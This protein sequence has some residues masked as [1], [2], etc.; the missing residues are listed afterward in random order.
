MREPSLMRVEAGL[1]LERMRAPSRP[2]FVRNTMHGLILV[3]SG[4]KRVRE[5]GEEWRLCAGEGL[6]FAQGNHFVSHNS[7]D[8]RALTLF[9][10]DDYLLG[11]IRRHELP[12]ARE[13]SQRAGISFGPADAL[14]ALL[15][16][17]VSTLDDGHF[18]EEIVRLKCELL[19]LESWAAHAEEVGRFFSHVRRSAPDCMWRILEEHLD[20]LHS[21]EE[22]GRLLEMSPSAFHRRFVKE[23][24]MRPG[25]W[26]ESRRMQKARHLLLDTRRSVS[27]IAAECGYATVSHFIARFRKRYGATPERFRRENDIRR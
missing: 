6:F 23:F 8:Y 27:E 4:S 11:L 9:F 15:S 22:M 18:Q 1:Y 3:L 16:S 20:T 24:G 5:E 25:E 7:P 21:V 12:F 14:G 13:E 17:L 19:L 2:I 10:D 26:L